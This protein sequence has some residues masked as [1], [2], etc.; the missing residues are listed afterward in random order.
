MGSG[1]DGRDDP[2]HREVD[3]HDVVRE[4]SRHPES[5]AVRRNREAPRRRV[6]LRP[7]FLAFQRDRL[8][9]DEA[10]PFEAIDE[11]VLPSGARDERTRPVRRNR[12]AEPGMGKRLLEQELSRGGVQEVER[13]VVRACAKGDDPGSIRRE[14]ERERVRRDFRLRAR[15]GQQAAVRKLNLAG[16]QARRH[17]AVVGGEGRKKKERERESA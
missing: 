8:F 5:R 10:I 1:R 9:C 7:V 16:G 2:L 11:D 13:L 14:R 6:E 4:N 17:D 3:L 15:G 12:E